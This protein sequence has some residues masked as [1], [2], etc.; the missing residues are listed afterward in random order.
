MRQSGHLFLES[1]RLEMAKI[2]LE[3][4]GKKYPSRPT[5]GAILRFKTETGKEVSEI[6]GLS[7]WI[8]YLYCCVASATKHDTGDDFPM[9]LMDFA[10]S[11]PQDAVGLWVE[12]LQGQTEKESA[13][14]EEEKKSPQQ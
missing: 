11:V 4:N 7:D 9:S 8:T 6:S 2:E 13:G 5:M 10:D 12:A 14:E 3:V 1:I